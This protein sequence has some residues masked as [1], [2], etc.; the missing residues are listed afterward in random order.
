MKLR[1]SLIFF[2]FG[3]IAAAEDRVSEFGVHHG[4]LFDVGEERNRRDV[5][6]VMLDQPRDNRPP[7]RDVIF[8]EKL[9]KEFQEQYRYRF[10]RS[11]AEQVLNTQARFDGY[12]FHSGENVT[13]QEYQ[14][15]QRG[16]GEFMMRR[17]GEYHID[18]WV[19]KDPSLRPIH[20]AKERVSNLNVKMKRGY[21][22]KWKYNLS[23][24][25]MEFRVENPYGVD[26]QVRMEMK[27]VLSAP[28]ETM[29]SLGYPV[30]NRVR[31]SA[32][33][34]DYDQLYQ[35]S[36]GRVLAP[37]MW[38]SLTYSTDASDKGDTIKQDLILIGFHWSH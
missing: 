8:N 14:K 22:L 17:L 20:T 35:V 21:N 13:V 36:V 28:V 32:L 29:Y 25:H 18:Q 38:G 27:G 26:A 12:T 2:M 31:L 34:K 11:E 30:N 4:Y 23:G 15:R 9:S 1:W 6:M 33:H 10:G 19:K 16:F 7:L 3:A 37:G 24:P 5:E